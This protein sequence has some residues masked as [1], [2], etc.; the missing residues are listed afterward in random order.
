M[1]HCPAGR[2]PIEWNYPKTCLGT[3]GLSENRGCPHLWP[4]ELVKTLRGV[5]NPKGFVI[6]TQ[7][8]TFSDP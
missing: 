4:F 6:L 7:L 1:P 2:P 3:A 5:S 8:E